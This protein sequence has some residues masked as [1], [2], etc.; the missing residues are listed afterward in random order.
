MVELKITM[1]DKGQIGVNGP[2][3]DKVLCY[4]LLEVARDAIKAFGE[5]PAS[6]IIPVGAPL[7]VPKDSM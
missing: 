1:D 5:R 4:G 6:G 3:K 2:L 7:L